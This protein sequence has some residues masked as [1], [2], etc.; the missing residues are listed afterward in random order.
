MLFFSCW[1]SFSE[2]AV[3]V[4]APTVIKQPESN[5]KREK[6]HLSIT[7]SVLLCFF[8]S[9]FGMNGNLVLSSALPYYRKLTL[10]LINV[11]EIN[12]TK[13]IKEIKDGAYYC[14]CAY[15]L[16]ISRYSDFLWV[17]LINTEIFFARFKTMRRKQNLASALGIQKENWG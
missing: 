9:L 4:F 6:T 12:A 7:R 8:C 13:L 10:V 3:L 11:F 17:V 1:F 2:S 15:V 5:A 14:Y 16:R